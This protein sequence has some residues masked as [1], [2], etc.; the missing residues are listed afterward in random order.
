MSNED[1]IRELVEIAVEGKRG[2]NNLVD[3]L[4]AR[5]E[6]EGMTQAEFAKVLG[7]S[8]S[9]YSEVRSGKRR[10]S[11]DSRKRAFAIGIPAGVLLYRED[12]DG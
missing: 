5:R 4:E 6:E 12:C 10:L 8:P 7:I 9:L 1:R 11:L 3:V 2:N